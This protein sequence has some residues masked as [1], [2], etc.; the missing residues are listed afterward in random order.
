MVVRTVAPSPIVDEYYISDTLSLKG[1]IHY[2][3][4]NSLNLMTCYSKPGG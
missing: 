2:Q 3:S 1:L 4:L